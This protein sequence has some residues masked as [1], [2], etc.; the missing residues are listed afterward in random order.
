MRGVMMLISP[1]DDGADCFGL[2]SFC[3]AYFKSHEKMVRG[4]DV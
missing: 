1:E 3:M 4:D 2:C